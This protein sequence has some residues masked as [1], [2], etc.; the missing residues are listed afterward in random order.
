MNLKQLRLLLPE[1][2]QD[3]HSAIQLV[4]LEPKALAPVIPEML[5]HL[6]HSK[7]PVA[8][9][10]CRFFALHGEQYVAH[11]VSILA[12]STMPEIKYV[13]LSSVLPVWSREGVAACAEPLKML[14]TDSNPLNYDLLAIELLARHRLADT[15][16]LR[17]WLEF[18]IARNA[19][20]SQLAKEVGGELQKYGH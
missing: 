19:E 10:F 3:V 6:K 1:N 13:I 20:R 17:G 8:D 12:R 11:V 15:D 2:A 9:T 7:S 5:R 14:V 4:A 18:K 16:W